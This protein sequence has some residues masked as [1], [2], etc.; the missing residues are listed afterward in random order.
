MNLPEEHSR[1][2]RYRAAWI[3]LLAVM[4]VHHLYGCSSQQ[5]YGAGQAWQLQE[6]SKIMDAQERN[7]CM[8]SA[9]TSYDEYK[10]QTEATKTG[11]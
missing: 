4:A 1:K 11:Q 10:R 9:N 6:C 3:S 5:V 7:R 2:A 8:S